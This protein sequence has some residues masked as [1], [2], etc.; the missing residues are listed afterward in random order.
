M[1]ELIKE[2]KTEIFISVFNSIRNTLDN[3]ALYNT[4]DVKSLY[5]T[6]IETENMGV[7]N[8]IVSLGVTNVNFFD[9][10]FLNLAVEIGNDDAFDLIFVNKDLK[11]FY[12]IK[13]LKLAADHDNKYA[14][15][16]YC[17][18]MK[19]KAINIMSYTYNAIHKK[20]NKLVDI[21]YKYCK[22]DIFNYKGCI[23]ISIISKNQEKLE[24]FYNNSIHPI[25]IQE[26]AE[27]S[28]LN[29]NEDA[30]K[31]LL[32]KSP[33]KDFNFNEL[34]KILY[35]CINKKI[36]DIISIY[37]NDIK[38]NINEVRDFINSRTTKTIARNINQILLKQYTI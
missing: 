20:Y 19:I 2:Q 12:D 15:K 37:Q 22:S 21:L 4:L 17:D 13:M 34:L 11:I 10:E 6:S 14:L 32:K 27:M 24:F 36:F 18:D 38:V 16:V 25:N 26:L 23:E 33:I 8:S 28:I 1:T 29:D 5:K 35:L 9:K 30:L 31:F 7:F 3:A